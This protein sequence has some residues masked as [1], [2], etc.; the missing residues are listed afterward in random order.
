MGGVINNR[1][2]PARGAWIEMRIQAKPRRSEES[3]PA[4]GAWIE[5]YNA[6]IEDL[7]YI[8][9]PRKGCVD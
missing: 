7:E 6:T 8:V 4:R 2:H 3:H 1:S 5:I 9:A